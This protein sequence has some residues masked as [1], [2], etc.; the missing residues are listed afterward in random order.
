MVN[1]T[2]T[3]RGS[4]NLA[5]EDGFLENWLCSQLRS[6]EHTACSGDDLS[7]AS[8]DGI[9][10]E[11]HVHDVNLDV[12]P[13][14][15]AQYSFLASPLESSF[16]RVFDFIQILN[17]LRSVNQQICTGGFGSKTPD[18]LGFVEVP[19]EFVD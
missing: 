14:L 11:G 15:S 8:V 10:M 1:S 12:S 7:T 3:V 19:S 17:S 4:L 13:V 6:V 18:L 2:N 5:Q 9:S 16:H